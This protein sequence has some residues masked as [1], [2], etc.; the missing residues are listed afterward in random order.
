MVMP[1][2][3][4]VLGLA[5]FLV[6][7]YLII[8]YAFPVIGPF[9]VALLI[10]ELVEPVVSFLN[11]RL[12][13]PRGLAVFVVLAVFIG[14]LS[15]ALIAGIS[16]LIQEIEAFIEN[17]PFMYNAALDLVDHFSVEFG[18]FSASL[19][20]YIQD[21]ITENLAYF[22]NALN[23]VLPKLTGTLGIVTSLPGLFTSLLIAA[24]AT[25]FMSRDRRMIGQFLLSLFPEAWQPKMRVVKADVW[26][27]T[28]GWAKAQML[29][30]TLTMVQSIIGLKLIGA[31]YAVLMGFVVGVADVLPILGPASVYVPWIIFSFVFGDKVFGLKLLILYLLVAGV[32]Q[33]LEPKVVGDRVG[34]HPLATLFALYVGIQFFGALG[35]VIGPLLAILLKSMIQ[36]GL[37][38][39]FQ[40]RRPKS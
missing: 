13:L 16:K 35:V 32:R 23:R 25:F 27:S 22:E 9:V 12:R 17:L 20:T 5:A 37:L 29:L 15:I 11:R 34:L 6:G 31:K 3:L 28:M 8:V 33:V 14:L 30:I 2:I 7:A 36:S 26:T 21:L 40:E 39:I 38:P 1:W 24:L 18:A 10:A 19:P 4:S